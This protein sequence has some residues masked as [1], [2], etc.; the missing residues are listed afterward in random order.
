MR[1]RPEPIPGG[2]ALLHVLNDFLGSRMDVRKL[3]LSLA[4]SIVLLAAPA[5]G[6]DLTGSVRVGD[7]PAPNTVIW[8][9]V[10]DAPPRVQHARIVLDQRNLRFDPPVL[11]VRVGTVVDFPNSDR[12]FH[13][14]FSFRDGKRFDLGMYPAGS[15]KRVTFDR[16]GL[17]RVFCNIHPNMAAYVMA[18]ETPYFAMTDER[19]VFMIPSVPPGT[20]TYHAWR[21][22]AATLGG[23]VTVDQQ[24]SL[25]LQW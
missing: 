20:Y 24:T 23:L 19:G 9:D 3:V 8:L 2:P 1:I 25:H 17:S 7:R 11:A 6:A 15:M 12:V 14:V 5:L 16:P 22:G 21:A 18:V 4:T 13:N 10:A